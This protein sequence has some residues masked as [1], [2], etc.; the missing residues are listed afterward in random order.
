VR[1]LA[2]LVLEQD[3]LELEIAMEDPKSVAVLYGVDELQEYRLDGLHVPEIKAP[4][5]GFE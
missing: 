4:G 2:H 1:G 3:V 5:D